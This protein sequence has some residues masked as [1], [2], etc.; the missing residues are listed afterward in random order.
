M[1]TDDAE[2]PSTVLSGTLAT[3]Q[4][5]NAWLTKN[6]IDTSLWGTGKAKRVENLMDEVEK[7][8]STL[9]LL[10]GKVFRCLTVVK[11]VV[12]HPDLPEHH[13][14]CYR[15]TMEDGR[16]RPRN[17]LPSEKAFAGE[18]ARAA[19]ERCLTEEMGDHLT[20][21][22]VTLYDDTLV[23]WDEVVE[24]PSF[25]GLC[26]QYRLYQM[27]ATIPSL[28]RHAF[29]SVEGKK[30][31]AWEW[32]P[33]AADDL[34]R[35]SDCTQSPRAA[36][37]AAQ[38]KPRA[39]AAVGAAAPPPPESDTMITP[40][41]LRRPLAARRTS[42]SSSFA[43]G[44]RAAL[45]RVLGESIDTALRY[46][47]PA[48]ALH[49]VSASLRTACLS[50]AASL[51]GTGEAGGGD[52][53]SPVPPEDDAPT[54][55]TQRRRV[56]GLT[57]AIQTALADAQQ[58]PAAERPMMARMADALLEQ[59]E[60]F[61]QRRRAAESA[62]ASAASDDAPPKKPSTV[63][64]CASCPPSPPRPP[65]QPHKPHLSFLSSCVRAPT[66][67]LHARVRSGPPQL[68]R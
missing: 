30:R 42:P 63:L 23:G 6:G 3:A 29:V 56:D 64:G 48:D 34:R 8:E 59:S 13:L 28:P 24:S 53:P 33:D 5:L 66:R 35:K 40:I 46:A 21:A 2:N 20:P 16:E 10:G 7:K 38:G 39:P 41:R 45:E 1:S 43:P 36:A 61:K 22:N 50:P 60:S 44:E 51:D 52:A 57:S 58:S 54:P 68:V 17:E 19:A 18:R 9:Y 31:H 26:T 55:G 4:E 25:P 49:F 12:R 67:A 14:A 47:E 15:Q 11:V 65:P 62:V 32:R 27:E 37:A